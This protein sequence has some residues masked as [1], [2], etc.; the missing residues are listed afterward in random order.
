MRKPKNTRGRKSKV[1]KAFPLTKGNLEL[2][3][4]ALLEVCKQINVQVSQNELENLRLLINVRLTEV[5]TPYL[6]WSEAKDSINQ[7]ASALFRASSAIKKVSALGENEAGRPLGSALLSFA[8]DDFNR[9]R[10]WASQDWQET[11]D[12]LDALPSL[13]E[14]QFITYETGSEEYRKFI[15]EIRSIFARLGYDASGPNKSPKVDKF[16]NELEGVLPGLVFPRGT[17]PQA[18]KEYLRN[19][20][21]AKQD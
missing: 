12:F 11:C 3:K 8:E 17:I 2:D 18:R 7:M 1:Q 20:S 6:D 4:D 13:V 14:Q 10:H 5:R 21:R 15:L 9:Y 16:L 19:I